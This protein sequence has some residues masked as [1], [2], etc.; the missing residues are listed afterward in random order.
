MGMSLFKYLT[1]C[2]CMCKYIACYYFDS[3]ARVRVADG[4]NPVLSDTATVQITIQRNLV[5]PVFNPQRDLTENIPET[6]PAG[7]V[8]VNVNATDADQFVSSS[9]YNFVFS[10]C[11]MYTGFE[12][13]YT[14]FSLSRPKLIFFFVY[15]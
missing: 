1:T 7:E 6:M 3:Q 4:G 9:T 10:E 8:V 14:H 12:M 11:F 2:R 15:N 5:T 13:Q